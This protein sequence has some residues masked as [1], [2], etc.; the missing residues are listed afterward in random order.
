MLSRSIPCLWIIL[1]LHLSCYIDSG[2]AQNAKEGKF[3]KF[4][5]SF[6]SSHLEDI[7]KTDRDMS[8]FSMAAFLSLNLTQFLITQNRDGFFFLFSARSDR[9]GVLSAPGLFAATSRCFY[10]RKFKPYITDYHAKKLLFYLT[11]APLTHRHN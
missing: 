5:F 4:G 1:C 9:A 11:T 2:E 7:F 10:A 8:K 3:L 6:I